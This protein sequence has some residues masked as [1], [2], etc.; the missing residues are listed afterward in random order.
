MIYVCRI[1]KVHNDHDP[2]L[3]KFCDEQSDY[4]RELLNEV[5]EVTD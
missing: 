3:C 4:K 2:Q 1:C 5:Q